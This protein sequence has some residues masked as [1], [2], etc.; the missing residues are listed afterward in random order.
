M[1]KPDDLN[2]KQ[3]KAY[4]T[5]V[6]LGL[7]HDAAVT[8]LQEDGLL[9]TTE[10]DQLTKTFRAVLAYPRALRVLLRM[11][12]VDRLKGQCRRLL[13]ARWQDR[14]LEITIV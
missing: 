12:E 11:V 8:A 3:R 13:G 10:H 1:I 5:W 14:S 7:T 2:P 6:S 9:Q 4:G